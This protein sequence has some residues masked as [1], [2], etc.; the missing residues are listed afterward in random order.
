MDIKLRITSQDGT[1]SETFIGHP[2]YSHGY[3][4][5]GN[6][7]DPTMADV[8]GVPGRLL[9]T[10]GSGQFY[11]YVEC[12]KEHDLTFFKTTKHMQDRIRTLKN[13]KV[14]WV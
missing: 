7:G 5:D 4:A 12:G 3:I 14:R 13:P 6:C 1:F 8:M 2:N 9:Y 10:Y 11:V